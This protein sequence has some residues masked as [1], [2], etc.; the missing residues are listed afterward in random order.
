MNFASNLISMIGR[1]VLSK[2]SSD[3]ISSSENCNFNEKAEF[4]NNFRMNILE[5]IVFKITRSFKNLTYSHKLSSGM[6]Y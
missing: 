4:S 1:E 5:F 3:I 2:S 6:I